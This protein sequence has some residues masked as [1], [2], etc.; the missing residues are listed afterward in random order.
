MKRL[1]VLFLLVATGCVAPRV[2]D[3]P[4]KETL[5]IVWPS[6]PDPV[7]ISFTR[8][9][10]RHTDLGYQESLF[11]RMGNA[12]AGENQ[13]RLVRPYAIAINARYI[14]VADPGSG[15]THIYDKKRKSY[16]PIAKVGKFELE[17]PIS[18]AF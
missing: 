6:P 3:V 5:S 8:T 11:A 16:R 17:S 18:V 14:A 1:C 13:K 10:A 9:F 7:R 4:P 15:L 12:L 2:D